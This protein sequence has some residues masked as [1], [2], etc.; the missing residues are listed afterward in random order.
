[1]FPPIFIPDKQ[2][3]ELRINVNPMSKKLIF[4]FL[5]TFD[6]TTEK[7]EKVGEKQSIMSLSMKDRE[8]SPP[9]SEFN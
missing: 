6:V 3:H 5:F 9:G 2:T 7:L 8:I 1:M 4:Y